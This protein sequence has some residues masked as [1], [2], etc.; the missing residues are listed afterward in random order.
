MRK[1]LCGIYKITCVVNNVCY[2]G[3][4]TNIKERWKHHKSDLKSNK[5]YNRYLQNIY[6]KYGESNFLYEILEK[7]SIEELD[8]KEKYWIAYFG[9]C[10]SKMNCNFESGGHKNKQM[11]KEL[12]QIQSLS[13]KGKRN[14]PRTE[15]QKGIIPWNKGKKATNETKEKLRIAHLGHKLT[16]EQKDW[17]SK[18]NKGKRLGK[19]RYNSK[20]VLKIDKQGN[21]VKTYESISLAAKDNGI[22]VSNIKKRTKHNDR[23]YDNHYWKLKEN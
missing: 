3:Q 5:H 4:S 20:V 18:V 1:D 10:N 19:E 9:G 8:K 7:C 17:L 11:S 22:A 16:Q 12:K 14:S 6:N 23:L 2:V 13:H 21:I 15:F